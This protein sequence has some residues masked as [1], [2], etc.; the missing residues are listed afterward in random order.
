MSRVEKA[1]KAAAV[2]QVF[3][4]AGLLLSLVAVPLYLRWLGQ[5]R[6]GFLLTGL[7]LTGYLMFSDAGLSWASMVLISHANGRDDRQT[8]AAIVRNSLSLSACSAALVTVLVLLVYWALRLRIALPDS[9]DHPEFPGL[10]LA[11][12]AYVLCNL[13][14]STFHNLLIGLQAAEISA[15]YQGGGRL[16]GTLAALALASA[17]AELGLVFS[18]NVACSLVFGLLAALHS[19]R[20]YRWAF[21]AGRFWQPQQIRQQLRTGAKSLAVQIGAVL[22]GTTPVMAISSAM[23]AE[24]V[25]VFAVPLTLLNAPLSIAWSFNSSLQAGYGE[26]FGRG[27]P[28]WVAN[29]VRQILRQVLLGMGLLSCG[30]MLL[31][32][33]FIGLWTGMRIL[34]TAEVLAN[35]L[36]IALTSTLLSVFRFAST[37]I[38]RHGVVGVSDVACGLFAMLLAVFSVRWWGLGSLA[39]SMVAAAA[40]TSARILPRELKRALQ[41]DALLPDAGFWLRLL[42]VVTA[43]GISGWFVLRVT[44]NA[45]TA[46][47]I[48][49]NTL[50]M[51]CIYS[52]LTWVLFPEQRSLAAL[53][54]NKLV[55]KLT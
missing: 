53:L 13:G 8:I 27:E 14:L 41:V 44:P 54:A 37:G 28:L 9:W 11:V 17:G 12:G 34:P 35:V 16:V 45:A 48:A 7:A 43:T 29:T 36:A 3:N 38:N 52:A 47:Y 50:A 33:P 19:F 39:P 18:A 24:H 42:L 55:A 32:G 6:Y 25:P 40:L 1:A 30:F 10:V 46:T 15:A 51:T 23:G 31:A 22:W 21:Q 4:W 20:R 5:E 26:A 49:V 2:A